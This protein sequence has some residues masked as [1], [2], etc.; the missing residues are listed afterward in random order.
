MSDQFDETYWEER[1]RTNTAVWSGRPNPQLVTETADLTP[2]TALE[3]GSGEPALPLDTLGN[4]AVEGVS[5][6]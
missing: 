6:T 4:R 2:G 5:M 3:A 1:Y